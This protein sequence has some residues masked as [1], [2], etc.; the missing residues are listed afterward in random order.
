M[1]ECMKVDKTKWNIFPIKDI[2]IILNGYAFK[3]EKYCSDGIRIIRITNVQDGFIEDNDPKF[4][5]FSIENEL[6]RFIL[7]EGDLLISLTG[8]VGRVGILNDSFLPAAL[9]QRVGCIR[10]TKKACVKFLYYQLRKESFKKDC[11]R[12]AKGVAQLNMSTE[13]L[14]EYKLFVPSLSEQQAIATEL[15]SIQVMIDG[16][17]AQLAD[18][19]ALAQSIFLDMFG[20][21]ISNPKEW[22]V[23]KLFEIV[24]KTCALTYGIVQPGDEYPNGVPV[25][26]SIDM[27]SSIIK[28]SNLKKVNPSIAEKF[29]RTTLVGDEIFISCRGVTGMISIASP[30]LKG[31]NITRGL[32]SARLEIGEKY[33]VYYCLKIPQ[34]ND[35]IQSQTKGATL[36]QINVKDIR[37]LPIIFPPLPLQQ[38]FAERVE[39]IEKQKEQIRQQLADAEQLMAERMQYYFS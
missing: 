5:S 36:R 27:S 9:N 15:D 1:R 26:R 12:S 32:V 10:P 4:Y 11:I 16:Y 21:P 34:L 24:Q 31:G 6:Q 13:W 17:K 28:L 14:K 23:K 2:A 35:L 30:E 19:D 29:K 38:Q 20:D 39:A 25:V 37:L 33:F 3:S 18:L 22:E 7:H 8:N